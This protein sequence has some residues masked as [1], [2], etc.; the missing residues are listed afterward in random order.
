MQPM[1]KNYLSVDDLLPYNTLILTSIMRSAFSLDFR[2]VVQK[3]RREFTHAQNF[4]FKIPAQSVRMR[5]LSSQ[6]LD[7]QPEIE[8]RGM[9]QLPT[10]CLSIEIS[11]MFYQFWI[12]SPRHSVWEY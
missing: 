4:L 7:N 9:V 8:C 6:F 3:L 5:E 11:Y 2:L 10:D 12:D 1:S